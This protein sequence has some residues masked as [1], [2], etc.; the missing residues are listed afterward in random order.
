MIDC[1]SVFT[2]I[3][4]NCFKPYPVSLSVL[5]KNPTAKIGKTIKCLLLAVKNYKQVTKALLVRFGT[6]DKMFWPIFRGLNPSVQSY[7]V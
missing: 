4:K 7:R 5:L 6:T 2:F 1:E 3:S